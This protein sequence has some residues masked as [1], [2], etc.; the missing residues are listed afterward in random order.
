LISVVLVSTICY[1]EEVLLKASNE[2]INPLLQSKGMNVSMMQSYIASTIKYSIG[3]AT[4]IK[5]FATLLSFNLAHII[6]KKIR[7][8]IRPEFNFN[9]LKIDNFMAILPLVCLTIAQ[10]FPKVSFLFSGL[11]VVGLFAPLICGFLVIHRFL[12]VR[13][14]FILFFFLLVLTLPTILVII[15]LGIVDSFH[16]IG[17]KVSK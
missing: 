10:V 14:R 11:F 15:I 2:I 5:M 7:K 16:S 9:S 6:S 1:S 12:N 17:R 13:T 8:N 3:M 4:L